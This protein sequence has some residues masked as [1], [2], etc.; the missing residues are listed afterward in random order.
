MQAKSKEKQEKIEKQAKK[1]IRH[2]YIE[3]DKFNTN[4]ITVN[5]TNISTVVSC[6]H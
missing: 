5:T 4:R 1:K 3:R 2:T 6:F